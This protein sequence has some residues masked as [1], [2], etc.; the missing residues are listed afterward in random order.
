MCCRAVANTAT[1][2]YD[3]KKR[4]H[5][6][7]CLLQPFPFSFGGRVINSSHKKEAFIFYHFLLALIKRMALFDSGS[8]LFKIACPVLLR[9]VTYFVSCKDLYYP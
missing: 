5:S 8:Q 4:G 2:K 9:G 6:K 7:I 3:R 1:K